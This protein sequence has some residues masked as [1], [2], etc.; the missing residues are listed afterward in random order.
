MVDSLFREQQIEMQYDTL[1]KMA[2]GNEV[3]KFFRDEGRRMAKQTLFSEMEDEEVAALVDQ[4]APDAYSFADS[5]FHVLRYTVEVRDTLLYDALSQVDEKDRNVI[6]LAYWLDM[7]D[8]EISDE[9][10]IPRST[11][12]A[13]K[14]RTYGKLKKIL[15]DQGYGANSFFPKGEA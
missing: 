3:K 7:T 6:L 15:E 11:V 1:A 5:E 2:L 10:G 13:I 12:N 14:R 8:L 4:N 9:T